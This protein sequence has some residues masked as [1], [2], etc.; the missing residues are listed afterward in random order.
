MSKPVGSRMNIHPALK[1]E[2]YTQARKL[3]KAGQS[4]LL[5]NEYDEQKLISPEWHTINDLRGY[6]RL[7]YEIDEPIVRVEA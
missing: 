4:F 1:S 5:I 6:F 2:L 7:A 3:L